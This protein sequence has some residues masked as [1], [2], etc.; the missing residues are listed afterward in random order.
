M[1]PAE[2]A[3]NGD[4]YHIDEFF[5]TFVG[6]AWVRWPEI[7]AALRRADTDRARLATAEADLAVVNEIVGDYFDG[8]GGHD[9]MVELRSRLAAVAR[10]EQP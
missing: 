1:S 4:R 8:A 6:W 3:D 2:L 10:R 5:N 9:L 7:A